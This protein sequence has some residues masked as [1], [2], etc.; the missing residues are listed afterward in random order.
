MK[1]DRGPVMR[2]PLSM[3]F[4]VTALS[5]SGMST[6]AILKNIGGQLKIGSR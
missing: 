6:D 3:T 1:K 2:A 5:P 4:T